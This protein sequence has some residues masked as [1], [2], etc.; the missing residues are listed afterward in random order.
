MNKKMIL[1]IIIVAG[2]AIG[3]MAMH[4]PMKLTNANTLDVG[5]GNSANEGPHPTDPDAW[6]I[7]YPSI[8]PLDGPHPT[9]PDAW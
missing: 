6:Q 1:G 4:T 7:M 5:S 8:N 3:L 2:I 9:D